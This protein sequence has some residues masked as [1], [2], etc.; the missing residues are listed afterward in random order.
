MTVKTHRM[1]LWKGKIIYFLCVLM[2]LCLLFPSYISLGCQADSE[3]PIEYKIQLRPNKPLIHF[4][5]RFHPH[6]GCSPLNAAVD[7]Q[8]L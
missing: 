6:N 3:L 8:L 2:H 1:P 4:D 7:S 5:D